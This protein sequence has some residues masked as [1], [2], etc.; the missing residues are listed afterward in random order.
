MS[1]ALS[2][3]AKYTPEL[4]LKAAAELELRQRREAAT[5][6]WRDDVRA[7]LRTPHGQQRRFIKSPAKRK[8]IRA[9]RR[10]GKTVGMAL[11]A[12]EAFL[13]GRRVLYGVPTQEQVDRFWFEIK[14]AL[15]P[16]IDAGHVYKNETWHVVEVPGTTTRIKAKTAWNADTLRG[17]Y[18][19][20]L[21]LDE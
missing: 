11:L 3:R 13:A 9:G 17:D 20:L 5:A 16:A 6:P 21:I 7:R 1:Y 10:G 2:S 12:I 18:A 19:D 4:K 15:E 8:V 14:Q